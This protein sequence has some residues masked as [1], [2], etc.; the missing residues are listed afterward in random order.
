MWQWSPSELEKISTL[1]IRKKEIISV[2]FTADDL[3]ELYGRVAGINFKLRWLGGIEE[4]AQKRAEE[5]FHISRRGL[6]L[7]TDNPVAADWH[8]LMPIQKDKENK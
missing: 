7:L 4:L 6:S 5:G 3:E 2:H 1:R 8:S